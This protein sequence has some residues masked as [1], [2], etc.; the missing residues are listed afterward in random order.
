MAL[1]R[2]VFIILLIEAAI[3]L[4][5]RRALRAGE[6]ERLEREWDARHPGEPYGPEREAF[7]QWSLA[8][9]DRTWRARLVWLVMILPL[10]A[11]LTIIYLVNHI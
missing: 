7:M 4:I 5:V 3:Y 2:F 11:I 6:I 9:F 1:L 8:R 10:A